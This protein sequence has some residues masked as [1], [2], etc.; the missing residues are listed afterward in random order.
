MRFLG[1]YAIAVII[2]LF[3]PIAIVVVASFNGA[4]FVSFPPESLSG[5][6][7][8]AF[9]NSPDFT[10]SAITS[11]QVAFLTALI[12]ATIGSLAAIAL[13][14]YEFPGRRIMDLFFSL[15]LGLP[16][17]VLALA[18]L[19][20]Y[21]QFGFAGTKTGLVAG[22]VVL[23]TPFVIRLVRAS[24]ASYN[25]NL[26]L[27]AAGLGAPAWRVF[28]HI[29]LPL[30]RP[31][32]VG[33]AVFAFILSFDEVVVSLFLSGPSA[34]TLPVRIFIFLDQSPGPIVLA[35]G[36]VLVGFS[37]LLFIILE[38]TVG[39]ARAFGIENR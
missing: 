20:V 35:A 10:S 19:L 30:L 33:G 11:F 9:W 7:Y 24:F 37:V 8:E 22:H 3:V 39:V 13:S 2:F 4:D 17:V 16:S 12:S 36:S 29:T 5:R 31:G 15:P 34:V 14:R 26:E 25:A 18:L 21:T 27:A 28:L 6:W 23:T 1:A 38:S 32:I